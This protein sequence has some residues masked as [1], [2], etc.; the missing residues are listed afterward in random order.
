NI[1]IGAIH[2]GVVNVVPPE[3][4]PRPQ[5]HPSPI[6][7]RPRPFP[8]LLDREAEVSAA[9]AALQ[10]ATPVE[11][12]GQAGLGK[13]TLLRHL[14]HHLPDAP[15]PDGV[16]YLSARHQPVGDLLQSLFDAFYESD[17]PFK[18]TDAQLRH[19][20][21][22]KRALI[23][24]DDVELA[25]D[26]VQALMDAAPGCAFLLA[27]SERRLWGE[28]RA[29]ALHGLP[30]DDAL[31]LVERE[32]DRPLTPE[33][34]IAVQ[35]LCTALDGHPLCLLQAAA[36]VREEGSPLA[37]VARRTQSPSPAEALAS[38]ALKS[39]PET[40][41]QVLAVLAALG[42]APLHADH[43]AALAG[44]A[45]AVPILETLQRRGLVQAH[46]PRYSLAGALG[47]YL[48]Q[49]ED[50][51]P[52]AERALARLTTWAEEQQAPARL[53]E[54]AEAIL[55]SL[56][57]AT[58]TDH[59]PEVLRLG[60]AVEGALAL[61]GRWGAW[62]QVLQWALQ[63]ARSLGDQ[64][65]EAWALHQLG[66]RA[67]CLGDATAARTSLIRAL[68]LRESLGDQSG[69]VVSRHNLDVLLS[70]PAPPQ[71]PAHTPS[72]SSS[73]APGL[74]LALK[75]AMIALVAVLLPV[76]GGLRLWY[77]RPTPT[78]PPISTPTL[79]ATP[80]VMPT[81][82]VRHTPT[83]T[84]IST[85]ADTPIFTSTPT[86][87]N[88][89]THTPT[90]T[91]TPTPTNTPTHTPTFTPTP[92]P[93]I[94]FIA[95]PRTIELEQCSKLRW[96]LENIKAAYLSGGGFNNQGVAGPTGS[97]QVCPDVTTT[98]TLHVI[99]LNGR[100]TDRTV[101]VTVTVSDTEGPEISG[102]GT[103]EESI[104]NDCMNCAPLCET[105]VYANVVDP[106]GVAVV[107]LVY[108]KPG[109]T[110]W[111]N[112]PM[113]NVGGDSYKTTLNADNW[114]SGTL[115]FYVTAYDNHSNFSESGHLQMEVQ[116]CSY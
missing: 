83:A 26:E 22:G 50:L 43:L 56:E 85:P 20:L 18:P 92:W 55:R 67:L 98:Y 16:I 44:L 69:A 15:L 11:F 80:T 65:A 103:S 97:Q 74:P 62:G 57:W 114:E 19:A 17:V 60:W 30:P 87:T 88:T 3:Q 86:P 2:G 10:S 94:S 95:T 46:S 47:E 102:L 36:M 6:F 112:T 96:Q 82:T 99:K 33:E 111:H 115:E 49:V 24:L 42:D 109:E 1:Q 5:P 12:Y 71:E 116:Y 35:N 13:T 34:R 9:T 31:A 32:L 58:R 89:P 113:T 41:R 84:P 79:T 48:R 68:R 8:G 21:Q 45:D 78:P 72:I 107:K 7:L 29:V 81:A 90:F 93:I 101:T 106:S 105:D 53:L 14:A 25:R 110:T 64:A 100:T 27:S 39:L 75:V 52:W 54:E 77:F 37:E 73:P 63:A 38:E 59:W 66:S 91:S 76:L 70:L 104:D 28:G 108:K 4:Q 51:A 23:M 61:G 40:E